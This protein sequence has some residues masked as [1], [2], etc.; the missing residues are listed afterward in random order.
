MSSRRSS[1]SSGGE[2][3]SRGNVKL[4]KKYLQTYKEQWEDLP[5][6]KDWLHKSQKGPEYAGCKYCNKD[7]NVSS[8]KDALLKHK[9]SK[10][11]RAKCKIISTQNKIT[12]YST[13]TMEEMRNFE[14][15]VKKGSKISVLINIIK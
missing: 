13:K 15:S 7:I 3:T 11:H 1:S 9:L 4:K 10:L 2:G 6:F 14:Y 12:A 8:G 5:Q